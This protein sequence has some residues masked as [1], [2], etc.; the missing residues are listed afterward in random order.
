MIEISEEIIK[1]AAEGDRPAF[2]TI[3]HASAGYVFNVALRMTRNQE[4]AQ[5]VSQEVFITLY[6]KLKDFRH[7]SR[8]MTW[9]Y[10]IT[11]NKAINYMKKDAKFKKTDVDV[12]SLD[13]CREN[14]I[15]A[16][17]EREYHERVIDKLLGM[18]TPD[19]RA[20]IILRN[21]EGLSYADIA[22]V[23]HIKI[24][25]VRSRLKRA[26]EKFLFFRKGVMTNEMS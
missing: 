8:L 16:K 19:Q 22:K 25:A 2:E 23:L 10:R 26:R 20:C 1:K 24:N 11:V 18:L 15:R 4:A 14:E 5:E 6:Y 21:I 7:Q 13:V 17:V 12:E 3:Y 9:I